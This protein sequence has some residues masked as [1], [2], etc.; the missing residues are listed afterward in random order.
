MSASASRAERQAPTFA[1]DV[2][3]RGTRPGRSYID[4][5]ID[6]NIA[7]STEHLHSYCLAD[8]EPAAYDALVL[9]AAVEY[10]DHIAH[11]PA[12][13][14]RREFELRLP[15]HDPDRWNAPP[16][17][18]ALHDALEFLTGD[19]WHVT[20]KPRRAPVTQPRQIHIT[21]PSGPSAVIPFSEGLDSCAVA[22]LMHNEIGD[23]LIRVR[24]GTKPFDAKRVPGDGVK[25]P[26]TSIPYRVKRGERRFV[27]SSGRSRGFKFALM[28]GLAAYLVKAE[29][30]IV[31]ESGQGALGPALVPVGQAHPDFRNHP[32]FTDRMQKLVL[33]VFGHH[34]RYDFP[35]LWSTKG[36]T[37][38]RFTK[39]CVDGAAWR[40]TKSCWQQNRYAS[41]DRRK[42]QCGICAACMLRRL[43]VHAAGLVEP[44]DTYI[45]EDLRAPTFAA[46]AA[47]GFKGV[48]RT[49]M[50]YYAIAGAL[51]LDHLAAVETAPGGSARIALAA[52]Q[53][54]RSL[55]TSELDARNNLSGLVRRHG[56][57]WSAFTDSLGA[58]S[59]VK[60][61]MPPS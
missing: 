1:I 9:A 53:L 7:F 22:G 50:R 25:R 60:Q 52:A 16:V 38:A 61:W 57:E 31:P 14:W 11:R 13:G 51:H 40:T 4:C 19:R 17:L 48:A 30:V 37:L 8:W 20:F 42:R 45:W 41:V 58:Q 27:E 54:S 33:A 59:F 46:G 10:C 55:G 35:Q 15:C 3:E 43:S 6:R 49:S 2:V 29:R 26:F 28:S 23:R 39:Q 24:L 12:L 56:S 5:V 32:L 47:A 18:D 34:V 44:A 36:E 21:M